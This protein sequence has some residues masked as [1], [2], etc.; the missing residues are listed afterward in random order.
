MGVSIDFKGNSCIQVIGKKKLRS[1]EHSLIYDRI[2]AF[3]W[4]VYGIISEGDILI[5]NVPFID[6][7]IP[8]IHINNMGIDLLKNSNFIYLN[9][10]YTSTK[11]LQPFE[12]ACGTHPGIISDMQPFFTLLGLKSNGSS[13]IHD[14]R[15]PKRT[16]Y[17]SEL[18]KF[19]P[20]SLK[21]SDGNIVTKGP[22]QFK[23]ADAYATDLRGGMS[24]VLAGLISEQNSQIQ[25]IEMVLRGYNKLEEKLNKLKIK[26]KIE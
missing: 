15:Y 4:I 5:K 1:V 24:L 16:N 19:C 7:E 18:I 3:S 9:K 21:W 11:N 25:N 6:M 23:G 22:A 17:L 20:N 10:L 26:T 8:L 12:L 2:E 14:Y 13:R